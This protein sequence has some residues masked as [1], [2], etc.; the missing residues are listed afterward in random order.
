[1]TTKPNQSDIQNYFDFSNPNWK[2]RH[3][4][5]VIFE[6]INLG[7]IITFFIF[8]PLT[9]FWQFFSLSLIIGIFILTV[10]LFIYKKAWYRYLSYIFVIA[11]MVLA[12]FVPYFMGI[13]PESINLK[14]LITGFLI[15]CAIA[16][17]IFLLD[18]VSIE[19][20]QEGFFPKTFFGY[21]IMRKALTGA[22][23]KDG[24]T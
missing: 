6:I 5:I 16:D 19:Y 1:M 24:D 14:R 13:P 23:Y 18:Y 2:K 7:I 21:R 20:S 15:I 11:G 10:F 4:S 9:T 12:I 3:L 8:Y 17:L 22:S